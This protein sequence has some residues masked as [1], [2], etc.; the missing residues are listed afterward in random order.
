MG[1]SSWNFNLENWK[2]DTKQNLIRNS[3][4]FLQPLSKHHNPNQKNPRKFSLHKLY[5]KSYQLYLRFFF[6]QLSRDS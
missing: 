1:S 5:E 6:C 3:E 4:F 2:N